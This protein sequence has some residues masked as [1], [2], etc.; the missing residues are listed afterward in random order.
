MSDYRLKPDEKIDIEAILDDLE[1]Y[2]PKKRPWTWRKPAPDLE[3]GG[4]HYQDMSEP[5]SA[6]AVGQVFWQH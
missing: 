2:V 4:F 6:P 3:M 1:H 5:L